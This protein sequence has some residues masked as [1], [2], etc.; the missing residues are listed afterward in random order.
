MTRSESSLTISALRKIP[1]KKAY[2]LKLS[3]GT[4]LRVMEGDISLF[5]LAEGVAVKPG[6]VGELAGRYEYGSSRD[7]ALRLL[8]VRPRTEGEMRRSLRA[9][10]TAEPVVERLIEDLR[11]AGHLDDR[12]F[13]RLW[14]TEKMHGGATGKRRVV[15]ELRAKLIDPAI[16]EDETDR[17]FSSEDQLEIAGQLALKRLVRMAG[18]SADA[19]KRRLYEYLLRRGFESEIAAQATHLALRSTEAEGAE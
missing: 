19:K 1:R 5:T 6:L 15:A 10:G 14:A 12:V 7:A 18:I 4:E 2:L 9:R 11:N 3:D 17:A 8:K 13:A 16:A